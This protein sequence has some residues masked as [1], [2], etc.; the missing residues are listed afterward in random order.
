MK[1]LKYYNASGTPLALR[2]QQYRNSRECPTVAI[3]DVAE[4]ATTAEEFC[5]GI[6]A[7]D[8]LE[9][10]RIDR[11]TPKYVRLVSVDCFGNLHYLEAS[12]DRVDSQVVN[13]IE[14]H[15]EAIKSIL[16]LNRTRNELA[17]NQRVILDTLNDIL[18]LV[19]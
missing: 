5:N 3:R 18:D 19:K 11:V 7:L 10:Y 13:N 12:Y 14:I 9:H 17:P 4:E 15:V 2:N 6:N 8:L 16:K 1:D